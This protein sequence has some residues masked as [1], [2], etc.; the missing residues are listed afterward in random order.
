MNLNLP[1]YLPCECEAC[2]HSRKF[3]E[4][5]SKLSNEDREFM[6]AF[7]DYYIELDADYGLRG[8][9]EE[10]HKAKIKKLNVIVEHCLHLYDTQTMAK[11]ALYECGKIGLD[12]CDINASF[13]DV[14]GVGDSPIHY[15]GSDLIYSKKLHQ[16][17]HC[18]DKTHWVDVNFEA[19]LCSPR[20]EDAKWKEYSEAR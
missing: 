19:A 17:W 2:R 15:K 4:I 5:I 11:I 3:N 12:T 14:F 1:D 18:G 10:I 9:Y 8:A 16:C 20:C 7:Y 6:S 13:D